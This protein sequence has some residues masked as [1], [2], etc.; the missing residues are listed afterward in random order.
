M[1]YLLFP[2]FGN[3]YLL[4]YHVYSELLNLDLNFVSAHGANVFGELEML[5]FDTGLAK[6]E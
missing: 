5:R 1:R 3:Q 2:E 4:H 6:T